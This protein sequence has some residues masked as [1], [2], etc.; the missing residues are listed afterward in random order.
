MYQLRPHILESARADYS[1]PTSGVPQSSREFKRQA[2]RPLRNQICISTNPSTSKAE[3]S[4]FWWRFYYLLTFELKICSLLEQI[5]FDSFQT[6]AKSVAIGK[7][8][9]KWLSSKSTS[10]FRLLWSIP[11]VA[12]LITAWVELLYV[13]L[14]VV[15]QN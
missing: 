5:D 15:S 13:I 10:K 6:L 14:T 12:T 2:C 1:V 9:K 7:L 3:L 8:R 11:G 4:L